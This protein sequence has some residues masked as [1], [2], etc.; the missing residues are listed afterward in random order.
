LI[1]CLIEL[2]TDKEY[3][4]SSHCGVEIQIGFRPSFRLCIYPRLRCLKLTIISYSKVT[5]DHL[6]TA[7]ITCNDNHQQYSF[8]HY[9]TKPNTATGEPSTAS[10]GA[11]SS[12][13]DVLSRTHWSF[14]FLPCILPIL[15]NSS[16]P[17]R[18]AKNTRYQAQI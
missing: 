6:A 7:T 1:G 2:D 16:S 5:R 4:R 3:F 8:Q 13:D 11:S 9:S 12:V 15:L 17:F 10:P 18:D 14:I